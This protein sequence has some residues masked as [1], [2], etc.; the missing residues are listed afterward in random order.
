M[1]TLRFN[2]S[3]RLLKSFN[4]RTFLLRFHYVKKVYHFPNT[5][6]I[7]FQYVLYKQLNH[8]LEVS[9]TGYRVLLNEIWLLLSCHNLTFTV[10]GPKGGVPGALKFPDHL[11]SHFDSWLLPFRVCFIFVR[12]NGHKETES[13]ERTVHNTSIFRDLMKTFL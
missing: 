11:S 6:F 1:D 10:Q 5:H 9:G 4:K 12:V 3:W 8:V 13:E 2:G 7:T